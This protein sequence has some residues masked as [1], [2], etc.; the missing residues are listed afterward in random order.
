ME[1]NHHLAKDSLDELNPKRGKGEH[2]TQVSQYTVVEEA[3]IPQSLGKKNTLV[4]KKK[5][6]IF[7]KI[8][9]LT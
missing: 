7:K 6:F 2:E 4:G 5:N 8:A 3:T 9:I 1:N